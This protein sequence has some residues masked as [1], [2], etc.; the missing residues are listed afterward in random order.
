MWVYETRRSIE[1]T[2]ARLT[3][4]YYVDAQ[5]DSLQRV[6]LSR[7]WP[8]FAPGGQEMQVHEF[9]LSENDVLRLEGPCT[10]QVELRQNVR[11]LELE[12]ANLLTAPGL[13]WSYFHGGAWLPFDRGAG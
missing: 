5:S 2:P 8:L 12:T 3:D 9:Y 10:I 11:Y 1:A 7:P 13:R 4:V 6:D